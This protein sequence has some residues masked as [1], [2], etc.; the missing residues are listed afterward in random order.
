MKINLQNVNFQIITNDSK[1]KFGKKLNLIK[2]K[3]L[4]VLIG[5][6][7]FLLFSQNAFAQG[8]ALDFDGNDDYVSFSPAFNSASNFN[9][10]S[11]FT[12]ECWVK[13]S[14]TWLSSI[15]AHKPSGGGNIGGYAL[16]L[17]YGA[18]GNVGLEVDGDN[19][20][21]TNKIDLGRW[22]HIALVYSAGTATFYI[23]GAASG[24][25]SLTFSSTTAELL[26]GLMPINGNYGLNGSIDEVRIWNV[27]RTPSEI[28]T[29][30]FAPIS[31]STSGLLA[32]YNFDNGVA[33][34]TNTGLST[35]T[36]LTSNGYDGTLNNFDL[37]G[38]NSNWVESY[39]M[40]VPIF[41][42]ASNITHDGFTVN[43][44]APA[45]GIVDNGYRLTVSTSP[46]FATQISGSPFSA[47]GTSQIL[48]G[49]NPGTTYYYKVSSDKT[50]VTG[51]GANSNLNINT[52]LGLVNTTGTLNSFVS[53]IGYASAEQSFSVNGVGLTANIT[54]TPPAGYEVS[55][56]SGSGFGSSV[57]LSPTSGTVNNTTIYV[58]LASNAIGSPSG[59]IV[60]SSTGAISKN[61][62]VAGD[63][64]TVTFSA[65]KTSYNGQDLSC[66]GTSDGEI[67]V[68]NLTGTS[69]FSFSKNNGN[70]Y[71]V[72]HVFSGLPEN[73]YTIKVR[74]ANGCVSDPTV[75]TIIQ[76]SQ[77][78][79]TVG[80]N[81][82]V[83]AGTPLQLTGSASGGAGS[84]TYS[85]TGPN[86]YNSAATNS[87]NRTVNNV[88]TLNMDGLYNMQVKD[89]NNCVYNIAT[90]VVIK[91]SPILS[92]NASPVAN[93]ICDGN[94]TTI[95][96][97]NATTVLNP[98]V[99]TT[100]YS[101]TF[102]S[103]IG[104]NWTFPAV[105]P[106]NVPSIQSYDG[107]SVLGYLSNQ[108]AI[109]NLNNLPTHDQI[110]IDFDLYIHDTWDGNSTVSGPDMFK[111]LLDN[112]TV[113]NTTFSNETW[114]STTQ[115]FPNDFSANNPSF[116]G[117]LTRT[118]PTA[119]NF[120]GGSLSAKYHITKTIPHSAATLEII[121]EAS[122]LENVCN[123]SW[124][125]DNLVVQ[126][127]S[128]SS[129]TNVSWINP[130]VNNTSITVSPTTN[131]Y[132]V[133]SLD[134]CLDSLEIIVNPT[135]SADFSINTVNQCVAG[136]SYDFTNNSTLAGGGAMTYN[137]T[138]TGAATN[139]ATTQDV[140]ANTYASH[141]TYNVRLVATSVIGNCS[142]HRSRVTK[143]VN[144]SPR[145]Q[146]TQS[147]PNP[148][149]VGSNVRLT[150]NQVL[151]EAGSVV[152]TPT[153]T[154]NFENT[155]SSAWS[156]PAIVPA[157]VPSIQSYNGQNVL[158]Y[159]TNQKAVY[160]Q[161][162]LTS[163]DYI[164]VE[165]DLYLHDSWDG[166]A[167]DIIGGSLI[168]KDIWKMNV[169]GS[170]VI[171]TTFS[172][173]TYRTQAYPNNIPSIN[174]NGTDAVANLLPTVCNHSG[175]ALSSVYRISKI[176]P[177]TAGSLNIEL[178]A[179]GLEDLCN[180]SWS[181]DNFNVE[182]GLNTQVPN[183]LSACN[184]LPVSNGPVVYTLNASNDFQNAVGS[185]WTFPAITPANEPTIQEYNG[186]SVLGFLTNQQAI[187]SQNGLAPHQY[188]KVEFDL[189]LH[190]TWDG[191][192]AFTGVDSWKM[193]IDGNSVINTTFSNFGYRTQS[194]PDN[195]PSTHPN[196]TG[197]VNSS[198]PAR[199]NLGGGAPTSK[200]RISKIV[201]HNSSSIS[202]VLEAMGLEEICNESWSIDNFE[203][204]LGMGSAPTSS[205][206]WSGGSV[207]GATSCFVD[208]N[209]TVSTNYTVTIGACT[210]PVTNID[211]R[212]VPTPSFT[213]DNGTC[214][215]TVDFVNTNVEADVQYVWNY[216]DGSP[217]YRGANAPSHTYTN[218]EY[219]VSLTASLG[220]SCVITYTRTIKI[221]DMPTASFAFT[222]G[223]GCG[224]TVQFT[225][226]SLLNGNSASY[227][228]N[229]GETPV[230]STSTIE[231][232]I[233]TF[234]ADGTYNVQLTVTTGTT[235]SATFG[236]SV[237]TVAA[238]AGNQAIFTAT[239][240]GVC[241]NLLTTTNASTGTG[242]IY[243]WDFG[244][245]NVSNE[246][247]PTHYYVDGGLKTVTLSIVNGV[248]CATTASKIVTVSPNADQN[249]RVGLDF[250]VS[251]SLSQ[252][253][254]SN[255]FAFEPTFVNMPNNNP[256]VYCAG[257]PTWDY[258]DGTGS[259][260]TSIYSKI[261]SAPGMYTVKITQQ[262]THTGCFAQASKV[263]TVL[264]N[265]L[266]SNNPLLSGDKNTF[267][268][269]AQY[270]AT[271]VKNNAIV[272]N[273]F[274]LF[275]NPN[276]G[277]FK[278]KVVNATANDGNIL[279][280]DVLGREIS[281][282]PYN[283]MGNNDIIEVN[284]QNLKSGTYYLILNANN[285]SQV[286]KQFIVVAD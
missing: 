172:N 137:W 119:C 102:S 35:L 60:C 124:S 182:L 90:N 16:F 175:G 282:L 276:K 189:Y 100:A 167:T 255:D 154:D 140:T 251:P 26:F 31:P 161:T 109:L 266:M 15:I 139:T 236:A 173:F 179:L 103:A 128:Q 229:F 61:I 87:A 42:T 108:Q 226:T 95:T 98:A 250:S 84:L 267:G 9:S 256:V 6:L 73:P 222:G 231:S 56:T 233:H 243:S 25:K 257:A 162:G 181:I 8:N 116:T 239:I 221:A 129:N 270:G 52:T 66:F 79:A 277:S 283:L 155:I 133:A 81:T 72:N 153:F 171:N 159:L 209:P 148:I 232:P 10:T 69:P 111:V 280:V 205:A 114:N 94:A 286:R 22:S 195:A 151:G 152:Y 70:T 264:P 135:P 275:P 183:L 83:C 146:I 62:A 30:S 115:S 160:S 204:S 122:G 11:T 24:S 106:A 219:T 141:G 64:T 269:A 57:S 63:V 13:S 132:Y 144:V 82:P 271:G 89:A 105:T 53:C 19:L 138:M 217:L 71:Q 284:T 220:T 49:L 118:L 97:T 238:I 227:M 223:N 117:S 215:K 2:I 158:G 93:T 272:A 192:D 260:N 185:A 29:S 96:C 4:T 142:D 55:T 23:N 156:F 170:N 168:G 104:S 78:T 196:F 37:T 80:S 27:A 33:S 38:S 51:T 244:D 166:N 207:S 112:N 190:D 198:L 253:L 20:I 187:Y 76:P 191:N 134:G 47:V 214:S 147:T 5:L 246:E 32:Y 46:T 21:A 130:A 261:Y 41:G 48:T 54:V 44:S 176:I 101:N 75:V 150:A 285:S 59:N 39:A 58:R 180:E 178:E 99:S 225:N 145:V 212:P 200:Y 211:V 248:G 3:T 121:L 252:V 126:Y 12:I 174:P 50:S 242:N 36:D 88:A 259:T 86:S 7:T 273:D 228:W 241:G 17:N 92:S 268:V 245:G 278:V 186:D 199:C 188:V 68:S 262:T 34:G 254:L 237:T 274:T 169:D 201:P 107:G 265:P 184:G 136:N 43:W 113:L 65:T 127:R 157:N 120:G 247:A 67:T 165:F 194:Y 249:G 208:V 28:I 224:S 77:I 213:L 110:T 164:K 131:T 143:T 281:T 210:S 149:C 203:L 218:G 18:T 40:V 45:T 258:G 197:A 240:G 206:S 125:I 193:D 163:H 235:C 279:I 202:I 91:A 123:E 74:D 216:G 234:I 263:V 230:A 85:W 1:F 14:S 177:H